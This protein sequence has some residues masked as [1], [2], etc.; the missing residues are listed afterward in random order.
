MPRR[1]RLLDLFSGGGSISRAAEGL[2]YEV[3]SV[4]LDERSAATYTCDIL[5]FDYKSVFARWVPD[6]IWA[7]P[8]CTEYS[9]AKT[10]GVR[11]LELANR[12]V[13]RTLKIIRYAARLNG[14]LRFIIENPQTGLLPKQAFMDDLAFVDTDYCCY[15]Y[16]YRKR[17]RLWNNIPDLA[18]DKCPGPGR[19]PKMVGTRHVANVGNNRPGITAR[20]V[21]LREKYSVPQP[22]LNRLL[23]WR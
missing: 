19:C 23:G 20:A 7:S 22:L 12:I 15:G 6:V 3:R 1:R 2:G 10:R 18:L 21:C 16:D 4:D 13:K 9:K 17:T 8:P 11:N 5:E 14:D